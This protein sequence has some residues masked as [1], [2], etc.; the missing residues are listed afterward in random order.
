M[1][2]GAGVRVAGNWIV[3]RLNLGMKTRT[4][5]NTP[6]TIRKPKMENA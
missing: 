5:I 4:T 2:V 1:E 6:T 3:G